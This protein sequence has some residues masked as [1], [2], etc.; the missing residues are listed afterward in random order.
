MSVINIS[1]SISVGGAASIAL[2]NA[3]SY[4]QSGSGILLEP[5]TIGTSAELLTFGD[6]ANLG[7]GLLITNDDT[8]NYVEIDSVN[9]F[10]SGMQQ[11]LIPGQGVVLRPQATTIYAKANTAACIVSKA[12]AVA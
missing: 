4:T 10:D 5:Q 6:L 11:K 3:S 9:T 8:T 7:G 2:V 12:A 1:A